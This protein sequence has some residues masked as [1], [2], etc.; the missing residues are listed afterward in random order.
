M[1]GQPVFVG[2]LIEKW[3]PQIVQ[4]IRY[5]VQC[6]ICCAFCCPFW[7]SAQIDC[8][9]HNYIWRYNM[10][11]QLHNVC[12]IY[13]YRVDQRSVEVLFIHKRLCTVEL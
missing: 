1:V 11:G 6:A 4:Q 12:I 9:E 5:N 7:G 2:L 13:M 10:D 3:C 8:T